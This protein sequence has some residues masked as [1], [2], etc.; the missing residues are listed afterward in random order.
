MELEHLGS[1]GVKAGKGNPRLYKI[2]LAICACL[3]AV[4]L[5]ALIVGKST[6][7]TNHGTKYMFHSILKET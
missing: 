3:C 5:L 4:L 1:S 2:A 7:H 6:T